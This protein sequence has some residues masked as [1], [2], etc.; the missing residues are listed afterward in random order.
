MGK[1]SVANIQ[2]YLN[3]HK[4]TDTKFLVN[5]M[6]K[7]KRGVVWIHISNNEKT[8]YIRIGDEIDL[9]DGDTGNHIF[10]EEKYEKGLFLVLDELCYYV[11]RLDS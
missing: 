7:T 10:N 3:Y 4:Q 6:S 2:K 8:Y 11:G 9:Y 1:F 5:G